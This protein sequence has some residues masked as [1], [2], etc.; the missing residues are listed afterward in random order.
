LDGN[1]AAYS[2]DYAGENMAAENVDEV[3]EPDEIAVPDGDDDLKLVSLA[4]AYINYNAYKKVVGN[5]QNIPVS[6]LQCAT[7]VRQPNATDCTK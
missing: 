4:G 7:G 1:H 2:D 5:N 3:E 6:V